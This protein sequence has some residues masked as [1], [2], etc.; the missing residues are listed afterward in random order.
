MY[1][2]HYTMALFKYVGNI[3]YF[4]FYHFNFTWH[5]WFGIFKA[6][7]VPPPEYFAM[8]QRSSPPSDIPIQ[9]LYQNRFPIYYKINCQEEHQSI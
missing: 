4:E 8:D 6:V 1:L 2:Y 9:A 3:T 5:K 7:P